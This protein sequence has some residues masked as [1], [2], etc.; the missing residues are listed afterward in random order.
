MPPMR[1]T[2]FMPDYVQANRTAY[3]SSLFYSGFV[4][5]PADLAVI[6]LTNDGLVTSYPNQKLFCWNSKIRG[7]GLACLF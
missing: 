5:F 1:T 2:L 3:V 7:P 6:F 4:S